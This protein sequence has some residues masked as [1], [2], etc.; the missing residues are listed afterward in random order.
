MIEI[1]LS[2]TKKTTS[3]TN[4]GGIDLSLINVK[5]IIL[6][7]IILYVPENF[8]ESYYTEAID[9]ENAIQRKLNKDFKKIATKVRS[10]REIEKQ[11]DALGDQEGKLARKLEVVKTIINKRQNPF[12]LLKYI[13]ENVPDGLWLRQLTLEN[14]NLIFQGYAMNFNAI[15]DFLSNLKNSIF[16]NKNIVYSAANNL[17]PE[18]NG[19]RMETFRIEARVLNFE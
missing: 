10:M 14:G 8:I 6:S 16:F 15:G 1:N 12:E 9:K 18:F 2:P 7:M 4:V 13:T 17:P 19:M 5:M 11:V 3:L